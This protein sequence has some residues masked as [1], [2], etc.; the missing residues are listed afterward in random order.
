MKT[1]ML[2]VVM[3]WLFA[4]CRV[5]ADVIWDSGYHEI[6]T[7]DAYVEIWLHND[8]TAEMS[9]GSVMQ[10]GAV[11]S[12]RFNMHG[13]SMYRLL[14]RDDSVVNIYG[15]DLT[16]LVI[17]GNENGVVNLHA[18][19]VVY[20]PSDDSASGWIDG[21]YIANDQYFKIDR[22][23]ETYFLEHVNIVPEPGTLLLMGFG[24]FLFGRKRY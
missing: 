14:V 3:V 1:K 10:L 13:G 9:D 20:H 4:A 15:G 17:Y 11:D 6:K 23:P 18:Y 19:D 5:Q 24:A 12:S 7:G 2:M 21:K 8:A 16:Y 22:F